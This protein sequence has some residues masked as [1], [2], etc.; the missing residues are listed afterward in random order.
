[1]IAIPLLLEL[2]I[3]AMSSDQA[4]QKLFAYLQ[5][6]DQSGKAIFTPWNSG[7][8]PYLH[9]GCHPDIVERLWDQLGKAL[10]ADCRVLVYGVPALRHPESDTILGIG[11]GTRYA[12]RFNID[13]IPIAIQAGA[14]TR[15]SRAGGNTMDIQQEFGTDWIFGSWHKSEIDW[16][17][18]TFEM[19]RTHHL[20]S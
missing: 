19:Y 7:A 13:L 6:Q 8:D 9:C 14:K 20:P 10:P 2:I 3:A 16:C 5:K 15:T 11:L 4:N 17:R 18:T 12:L 1:M